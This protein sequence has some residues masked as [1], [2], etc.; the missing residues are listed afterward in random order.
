MS[1]T[2]NE[3]LKDLFIGLG[4][5]PSQLADNS[6]VSDYIADLESA[7]KAAAT[8]ELPTPGVSNV[9]KVATVVENESVYSWGAMDIPKELPE[10]DPEDDNGVILQALFTDPEDE[11]SLAWVK[12]DRKYYPFLSFTNITDP[13]CNVKINYYTDPAEDATLHNFIWR[14]MRVSATGVQLTLEGDP[15]GA[16]SFLYMVKTVQDGNHD[17]LVLGGIVVDKDGVAYYATATFTD[18]LE[19]VF[20][21]VA[22]P[23]SQT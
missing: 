21:M 13:E 12:T 7:I 11:D 15:V 8:A 16:A 1:K 20:E 23:T 2:I 3:A 22:F 19:G 9:G 17:T 10:L 4:G 6:T 18:S 5:D 14:V